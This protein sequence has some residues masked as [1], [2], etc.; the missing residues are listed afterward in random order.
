[1]MH[2]EQKCTACSS[3]ICPLLIYCNKDQ[4]DENRQACQPT[5]HLPGINSFDCWINLI[6][7]HAAGIPWPFASLKLIKHA[8]SVQISK[9]ICTLYH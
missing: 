4:L 9:L 5:V 2:V 6:L 1:M 3:F 7:G 8:K